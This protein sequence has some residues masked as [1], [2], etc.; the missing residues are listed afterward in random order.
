MWHVCFRPNVDCHIRPTRW[1]Q[2][3]EIRMMLP[4]F[5]SPLATP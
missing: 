2:W 4:Q 5:P 3:T 1:C